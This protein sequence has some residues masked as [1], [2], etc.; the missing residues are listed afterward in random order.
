[1]EDLE[2]E[3]QDAND[4]K[5]KQVLKDTIHDINKEHEWVLVDLK[6]RMKEK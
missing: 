2:N 3:D 5:I 6:A 1:M 4:V